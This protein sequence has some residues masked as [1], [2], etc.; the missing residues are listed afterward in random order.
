MPT[1]KVKVLPDTWE[2]LS[3]LVDISVDPGGKSGKLRQQV[4]GVLVGVS[5]IVGLLDTL[6]VRGS[7]GA[8][9]VQGG[10]THPKLSHGMQ[11]LRETT[12]MSASSD[13][14][15]DSL[16][17]DARVDKF[18]DKFRKFSALREFIGEGTNLFRGRNLS[19]EQ[20]PEHALGEDLSA[21]CCGRELLLAIWDGQPVE[22]DALDIYIER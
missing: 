22:A 5:P 14:G 4:D 13:P 21:V 9:V 11:S 6:L 20:K 2:F 18:L 1:N 19:S 15:T 10:D 16:R 3:G 12:G 7:E 8:V 17:K